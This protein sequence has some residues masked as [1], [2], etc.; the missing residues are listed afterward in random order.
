MTLPPKHLPFQQM[1]ACV[2]SHKELMG[3]LC[4]EEH[5]VP[6]LNAIAKNAHN[7]D[8]A[9]VDKA[10]LRKAFKSNTE[11]YFAP[12][13]NLNINVI[14]NGGLSIGRPS[15]AGSTRSNRS[16]RSIRPSSAG[17]LL[18]STKHFLFVRINR[19]VTE[20]GR[21]AQSFNTLSTHRV[22]YITTMTILYI[23]TT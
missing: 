18:P 12:Y 14:S 3:R 2:L 19:N 16:N 15:S 9:I 20:F 17:A 11:Q 13:K 7:E 8:I 6:V 4:M 22:V 21:Y 10:M 5:L 23:W 1:V